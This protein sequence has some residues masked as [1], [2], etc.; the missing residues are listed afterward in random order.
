MSVQLHQRSKEKVCTLKSYVNH[1]FQKANKKIVQ[2][3]RSGW[4]EKIDS[5]PNVY[6]G[7]E[8]NCGSL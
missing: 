5:D 1:S 7:L 3:A 4:K 8:I 2:S 6:R